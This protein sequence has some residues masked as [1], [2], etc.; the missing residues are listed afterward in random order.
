MLGRVVPEGY[1]GARSQRLDGGYEVKVL[2]LTQEA[3]GVAM[4]LAPEAVIPAKLGVDRERTRLFRVERAQPSPASANPAQSYVLGDQGN[5][6]CG[7]PGPFYVFGDNTH[8]ERLR[9]PEGNESSGAH[10]ARRE[11]TVSTRRSIG[12]RSWEVESRSRTVTIL[13]SRE[14]KS[15]VTHSG[16]PISSWRR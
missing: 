6:V 1:P 12:T 7:R 4:Y 2:G 11:L 8:K 13:S 15:T 10:Q 14:S 9:P 3:D 5:Q 16:V